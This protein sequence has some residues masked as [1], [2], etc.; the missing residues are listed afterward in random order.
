MRT[1]HPQLLNGTETKTTSYLGPVLEVAYHLVANLAEPVHG[2]KE[3][4]T[5]QLGA[6]LEVPGYVV[7]NLTKP[8]ARPTGKITALSR[9]VL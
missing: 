5:T 7:A 9:E 2:P 8:L 1:S 4:T 3:E 6:A